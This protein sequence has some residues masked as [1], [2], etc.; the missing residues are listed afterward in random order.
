MKRSPLHRGKPLK[1][2]AMRRRPKSTSYSRRDRDMARMRWCKDQ[3]CCLLVLQHALVRSADPLRMDTPAAVLSLW[4][5]R[6]VDFCS[7]HVEAH[8]AG[9]H[10]MGA[11]A[12]DDTCIPLC[13]SHHRDL[14]DRRGVFAGWPPRSLKA[15]ELAAVAHYQARYAEHLAADPDPRY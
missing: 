7:G 2:S 6:E 13:S 9:E 3:N 11:K 14:T 8:H 1:R 10:G 5:G 15:W 12:D 4:F